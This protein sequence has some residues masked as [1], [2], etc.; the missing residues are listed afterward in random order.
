MGQGRPVALVT[1]GSRGI[2][3]AVVLRLAEAGF[4]VGFAYLSSAVA[5]QKVSDEARAHGGQVHC[6]RVD[7]RELAALRAFVASVEERL[8]PVDTLVTSAGIV[9]DNPMVL[10][11]D[12]D[13]RLVREVNLDG[14]Y[15]ACRAVIFSMLKRKTGSI[16]LL[17]S[18]VGVHGNA[19]Q[20]N[21]AA[22]KAGIIGLGK[23]LAK[24]V[25]RFGIRVNVVAPG[26]I[27]T[28]MTAALPEKVRD[29]AMAQIP[30]ARMGTAA[31]VADLVAF[32]ASD[33]ASYI[34]GQVL[35]VDGGIVI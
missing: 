31:E 32:L 6:E 19:T 3:A 21:Y 5:A 4:D 22:T 1:G 8:G 13:W 20:S 26:M 2:G 14:T 18:V 33:R 15:H 17:S 23:S 12:D 25:G 10:Q 16:I 9:R 29:K 34:T 27:D 35:G 30:L 24:E 7:V 28:D 11:G